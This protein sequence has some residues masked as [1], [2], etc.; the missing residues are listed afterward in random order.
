MHRVALTA[1][2]D[3]NRSIL[4]A[5][6]GL[7]LSENIQIIFYRTRISHTKYKSCFLPLTF[8]FNSLQAA[9]TSQKYCISSQWFVV[10][11]GYS[12][13]L[14]KLARFSHFVKTTFF[15]GCSPVFPSSVQEIFRLRFQ[16]ILFCCLFWN[17]RMCLC[18]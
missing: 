11:S 15:S 16:I 5:G 13:E 9:G 14:L 12:A 8:I 17:S 6:L 1:H 18:F 3:V 2:L 4:S 10:I 7:P